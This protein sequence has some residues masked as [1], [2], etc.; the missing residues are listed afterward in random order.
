MLPQTPMLQKH[1][2]TGTS[3]FNNHIPDDAS[4]SETVVSGLTLEKLSFI[5]GWLISKKN[6]FCPE[7][8]PEGKIKKTMTDNTE[9]TFYKEHPK[10][11]DPEDFWGQVKR[12]VNGKPIPQAQIDMIVESR[13]QRS[14]TFR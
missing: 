3:L 10:T 8:E 12:T 5:L 1:I 9:L 11:C 6:E 2:L 14:G 7:Y 13:L 4:A